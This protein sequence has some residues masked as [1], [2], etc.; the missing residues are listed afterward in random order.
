MVSSVIEELGEDIKINGN[1]NNKLFPEPKQIAEHSLEFLRMPG[2]RRE[3]LRSLAR[4]FQSADDPDN[5]DD[6][7]SI[8]GIGP[9]TVNY[10]KIRGSKDPDIFLAGDAGVNNA[11]KKL[12]TT[13][14]L[15]G[16][17]PWRSYFTFQLWNQLN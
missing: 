3:T 2:A 8:K 5:I 15:E 1:T 16:T 17:K 4:Y 14:I 11:L 13:P 10:V 9:W 7:L 6:W 12:T